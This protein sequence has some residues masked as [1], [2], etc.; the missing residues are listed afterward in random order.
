MSKLKRFFAVGLLMVVGF[1]AITPA[2]AETPP[3]ILDS[4]TIAIAPQADGT[5]VM[6]YTLSGY[7]VK[8][9][10]P[11]DEPY[12]QIGVPNSKFTITDW[13]A[14]GVTVTK[15]ESITIGGSFV[16]M[17]FKPLPKNGDCFNLRFTITQNKMAYPDPQNGNVTFKFIPAGWNFPIKVNTLTVIW[18]GPTDPVMLKLTEPKPMGTDGTNMI[19]MWSNPPMNSAGMFNDATIKLAYDKAAFA[20]SDAATSKQE[21]GGESFNWKCCWTVFWIVIAILVLIFIIAWFSEAYESGDGFG[22]AFVTTMDNVGEVLSDLSSAGGSGG[23]SGH[24]SSCACAGCACACACA[25][26]GRVG[27]SRK[28]IGVACLKQV[29]A[30][31]TGRKEEK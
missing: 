27:C 4:H 13:Y 1:L 18:N 16:Q 7:C 28:A 31:V 24:S 23:S 9:D 11:S 26:G 15:P 21:G 17:D 3:D 29:I 20:L 14:E 6:T 10:W 22:P 30:E 19:W 5:L 8:S 25:G 2:R 12:L